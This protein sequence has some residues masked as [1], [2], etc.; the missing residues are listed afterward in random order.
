MT[1][2]VACGLQ[3]EAA[4]IARPGWVVVAG[5]GDAARLERELEAAV[6]RGGVRAVLSCGVAGALDPALRAG[7][8]VVG[9]LSPTLHPGEGRGPAETCEVFEHSAPL[10]PPSQLGPGSRRGGALVE[11]LADHLPDAHRGTVVGA[12]AIIASAAEK[13][14]LY[15]STRAIAVDMESHIAARVAERH[16][17]PFA[18]LRTIS[19][20]AD[21]ALPPAAL[22]GMKPD[23][24][25]ALGAVLTSLARNPA[26]LPALIRTGRDAGTAFAALRRAVE[27]LPQDF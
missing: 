25:V 21:H 13:A 23:G 26:Q 22:V 17:L 2:L 18:I 7:D 16:S 3:R 14:A 9:E 1:L 5:G 8:V 20:T 15:A 24:G 4:I 10:P 6:E 19:D 27:G 11:W 12:D